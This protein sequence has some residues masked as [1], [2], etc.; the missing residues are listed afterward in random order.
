MARVLT[1]EHQ[2]LLTAFTSRVEEADRIDIVTAWATECNALA[3]LLANKRVNCAVRALVGLSNRITQ[4]RALEKLLGIGRVR[5]I[6][7]SSGIF[8]PKVYIFR[9]GRRTLGWTGSANFSS[10]GFSS[11]YELVLETTSSSA[12][13]TLTEW[14]DDLWDQQQCK[15]LTRE[16]LKEYRDRFEKDPGQEPGVLPNASQGAGGRQAFAK[17]KDLKRIVIAQHGVRPPPRVRRNGKR[18]EAEGR[19][20]VAG[21]PYDYDSATTCM[22][23][24]LEKLQEQDPSFLERCWGDSRFHKRGMRTHFIAKTKKQ[25]SDHDGFR[26]YAKPMD[27]GWWLPTQTQTREKWKVVC[28]AADVAGMDI[29]HRAKGEHGRE[30]EGTLWQAENRATIEVGF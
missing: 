19:V 10:A 18:K 15:P 28:A 14:F 5:I 25:L 26:K 30:V 2:Q 6:D 29:V 1:N 20:T 8:H 7:P 13:S 22:T 4:P 11:N 16:R 12:S 27:N 9:S 24:V 3:V 21:K 17:G 23:L